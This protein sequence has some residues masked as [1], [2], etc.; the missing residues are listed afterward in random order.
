MTNALKIIPLSGLGEIGKNMTVLEYGR[1]LLIV[2]CGV[3]FPDNDM[4]G[5]DER[6]QDNYAPAEQ[7]G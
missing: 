4:Y 1:D 3:K 5:I 6:A 7:E 2:D